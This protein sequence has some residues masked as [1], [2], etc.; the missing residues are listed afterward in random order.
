[1]A[2]SEVLAD[3]CGLCHLGVHVK[4]KLTDNTARSFNSNVRLLLNPP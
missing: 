3:C 1:M 2:A 4:V